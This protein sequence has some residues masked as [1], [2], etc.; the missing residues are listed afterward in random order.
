MFADWMEK[1]R[2]LGAHTACRILAGIIPLKSFRMARYMV[3]NVPGIVIPDSILTRMEAA[4][5]EKAAAEGIQIC[6]EI[7]RQV[8]QIEGVAGIHIM[9]IEWEHRVPEIVEKAGLLPR[10]A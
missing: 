7:I 2:S 6:S 4:P 1:V 9:A 3:E 8:K 10:P 5:K